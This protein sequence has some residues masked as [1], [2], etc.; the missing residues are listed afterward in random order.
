MITLLEWLQFPYSVK[1]K[2]ELQVSLHSTERNA[3]ATGL[4][5]QPSIRCPLAGCLTSVPCVCFTSY[6]GV[7]VLPARALRRHVARQSGAVALCCVF[8]ARHPRWQAY[9]AAQLPAVRLAVRA[10][11]RCGRPFGVWNANTANAIHHLACWRQCVWGLC[12]FV[13]VRV[14]QHCMSSTPSSTIGERKVPRRK[15]DIFR[16]Q[17]TWSK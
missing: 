14:L 11:T 9:A 2:T 8:A 17:I 12:V 5:L 16:M 13:C 4:P 1:F 7:P 3:G 6:S 10:K 15:S